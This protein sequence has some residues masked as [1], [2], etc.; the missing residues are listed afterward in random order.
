L[1]FIP[2]AYRQVRARL[3]LALSD[4][5]ETKLKNI[6]EPMRV[7]SREVGVAAKAKPATQTEPIIPAAPGATLALPDKP[8]IAV[9]PFENLSDDPA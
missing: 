4:L 8:S 9:L 1:A 5:G 6:V 3:D 2:D 7:Y